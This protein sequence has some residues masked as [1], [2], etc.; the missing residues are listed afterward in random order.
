MRRSD[1]RDHYRVQSTEPKAVDRKKKED[2]KSLWGCM[3]AAAVQECQSE[4]PSMV[5]T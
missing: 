4:S 5:V 1:S 2:E 3:G